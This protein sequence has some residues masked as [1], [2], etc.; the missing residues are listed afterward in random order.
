[1]Q[2]YPGDTVSLIDEDVTGIVSRVE[3]DWIFFICTEG[4]DYKVQKHRLVKRS[5][6][7]EYGNSVWVK[8]EDIIREKPSEIFKEKPSRTEPVHPEI[9]L[10]IEMLRSDYGQLDA[11]QTLAHQLSK[12]RAFLHQQKERGVKRVVLIHGRGEGVLK[13]EIWNE[14]SKFGVEKYGPASYLE[15]GD[16]ATEVVF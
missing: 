7:E 9:D 13:A 6:P 4:F 10:H 14:L 5:R 15:Y 16:G 11:T 8:G 3:G 2:F 12:A 1:M